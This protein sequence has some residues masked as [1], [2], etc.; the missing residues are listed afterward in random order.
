MEILI[1]RLF[2]LLCF[3]S[4]SG[5]AARFIPER[6]DMILA[7]LEPTETTNQALHTYWQKNPEHPDLALAMT[8]E[9]LS[10]YAK[11]LDVRYLG[12]AMA[13]LRPWWKLRTPPN[14]ILLARARIKQSLHLFHESLEDF[15][16]AITRNPTGQ[17]YLSRSTVYLVLGKL[18]KA[19]KDCESLGQRVSP[20]ILETCL[21]P[22]RSQQG[23][24]KQVL[25]SLPFIIAQSQTDKN[26]AAWAWGVVAEIAYHWNDP[27]AGQYYA[28]AID[29]EPEDGYNL[30]A[31][32][33][34]LLSEQKPKRVVALLKDAE[35][36][37]A[38][39][40]LGLA[41]R[42]LKD[43]KFNEVLAKLSERF[44]EAKQRHSDLHLREQ[45][46][47]TF[48]LQDKP[49]EAMSLAQQN[50]K[51]QKE[52]QDMELLVRISRALGED[53]PQELLLHLKKRSLL[54]FL[55]PKP[56]DLAG[57]KQ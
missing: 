56:R 42:Q 30:T 35:Q 36:D 8:Q 19:R 9:L 20:L 13:V 52:P 32:A 1:T 10:H 54:P 47:F 29:L 44:R 22:I 33:D 27:K 15:D 21:A 49:N 57:E 53:L 14:K 51:T 26:L 11:S 43:P 41:Y 16:L 39:L 31:Y 40:R 45:A 17:A 2:F 7:T 55:Q 50:W 46:W 37:S 12:R 3:L 23:E 48:H 38:L 4:V 6:D 24:G 18:D 25:S 5:Q 28:K 34:Y